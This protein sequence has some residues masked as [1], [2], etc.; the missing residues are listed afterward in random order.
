VSAFWYG[1]DITPG[2]GRRPHRC[3]ACTATF[4]STDALREHVERPATVRERRS[5]VEFI[6]NH[7]LVVYP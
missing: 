5:H 2:P 4:A 6:L 1:I 3:V 7:G